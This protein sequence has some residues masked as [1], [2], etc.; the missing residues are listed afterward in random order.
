MKKYVCLILLMAFALVATSCDTLDKLA[1]YFPSLT[2]TEESP[3]KPEPE[4]T[5]PDT[6][7]E[8]TDPEP[9]DPA[10][11]TEPEPEPEETTKPGGSVE[12]PPIRG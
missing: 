9:V 8:E 12:L 1:V 6:A 3:T 2:E 11:D 10:P 5:E 4:D 7:P